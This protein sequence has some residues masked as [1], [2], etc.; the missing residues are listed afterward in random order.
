MPVAPSARVPLANSEMF[1]IV[2]AA[3]AKRVS[4]Y[5]WRLVRVKGRP[6]AIAHN[7]GSSRGSVT[8]QKIV[9]S[10]P[11]GQQSRCINGNPLDARRC[12]LTVSPKHSKPGRPQNEA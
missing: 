11:S 2:D 4:A 6:Y 5:H 7:V 12:N 1:A 8:L 10:L 9:L 3:D